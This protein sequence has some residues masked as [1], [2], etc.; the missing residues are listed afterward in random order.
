MMSHPSFCRKAI[1]DADSGTAVLWCGGT[2]DVSP[3][4]TFRNTNLVINFD[5]FCV[6]I[7]N[8]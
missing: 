5:V 2:G 8:K 3:L 6:R 4:L 7:L 1:D